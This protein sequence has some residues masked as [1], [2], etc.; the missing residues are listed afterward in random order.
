[1]AIAGI[2]YGLQP[3]SDFY[4]SEISYDH[5]KAY[6]HLHTPNEIFK[7][8]MF[9]MPGTHNMLNALVAFA[10]AYSQGVSPDLL[11]RALG[12][13]KGVKRRFS[14]EINTPERVYID[15]Y[16]HHP[17][18]INAIVDTLQQQYPQQDIAVVFQPHL[19][20]RTKDFIEAF[21]ESLSRFQTVYLLEIYP[22]RE[23]PIPGVNA[24]W[25]LD[26]INAPRKELLTKENLASK[27]KALNPKILVSL[28]AGDIGLEVEKI[29]TALL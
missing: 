17:T 24:T 12:S 11:I 21:A 1:M 25:L 28:G 15:D 16:A 22:A 5:G 8:V 18:A 19:Y 23:L 10:M 27:L 20:S 6:A 3:T 14:Y 13:F 9:P 7:K 4:L 26:K 29:K 2:R